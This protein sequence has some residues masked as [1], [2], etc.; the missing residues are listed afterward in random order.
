MCFRMELSIK[1]QSGSK[2]WAD[3]SSQ[4]R[5]KSSEDGAGFDPKPNPNPHNAIQH[6]SYFKVHCKN[7]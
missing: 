6:K 3:I 1:S 2:F 5:T 4:C 7:W